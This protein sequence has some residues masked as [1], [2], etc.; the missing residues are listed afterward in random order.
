V[1][2]EQ[3]LRI[4]SERGTQLR[5]V[6]RL[7]LLRMGYLLKYLAAHLLERSGKCVREALSVRVVDKNRGGRLEL[8]V[9]DDLASGQLCRH[10]ALQQIR[11]RGAEQQIALFVLRQYGDQ[12]RRGAVADLQY[13]GRQR[14]R[15]GDS[16]R[17]ATGPAA[18]NG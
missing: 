17:H 3:Q 6:S 13:L 2:N 11:R 12:G 9:L 8:V 4:H 1:R 18:Q 5:F 14:G 10:L 15:G 7:H 16:D